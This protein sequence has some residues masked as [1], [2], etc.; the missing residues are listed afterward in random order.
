MKKGHRILVVG[1]LAAGPSAASKA[2]R[3]N[4]DAEVILIEQSPFISYRIC[5]IPYYLS[6][7]YRDTDDL[8][9]YSPERLTKDKG[10]EVWTETDAEKIEPEKRQIILR[11]TVTGKTRTERYDRLIITTGS[12]P[13]KLSFANSEH[14]NVFS[15][16]SLHAA[17][18]LR[19]YIHERKPRRAVIVGGGYIGLEMTESMK[20]LGC[21]VTLLHR[22]DY[23]FTD[24]EREAGEKIVDELE[25][26]DI[27]F[28]PQSE[29]TGFEIEGRDNV[30]AVV[31]TSQTYPADIVICAIGVS[32]N[33]ELA[34]TAGI[35][36]GLCNGILTN[37][38]QQTGVEHIYAAGDCCEIRNIISGKHVLLPLAT[39]ASKTG[40][41]AG[42]NAA[43]GEATYSGA[44]R[45]VA[46]RIFN[47]EVSRVGLTMK[48]SH[49]AEFQP[50]TKTITAFS[51]VAG[52]P[53][54]ERLTV[55]LIANKSDGR[56]LG[57][58]LIGRDGAVQRGN[59]LA[60]L[61][62]FGHSVDDLSNLDMM[63][64]PPFSTLWDPILVA[65]NQSIKK[66]ERVS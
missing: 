42:E 55:S 54:A 24:I 34:L 51:R 30:S 20:K 22:H 2:K 14:K 41:V 13:K 26:N 15:V 12:K 35:K 45:N 31:T 1:G 19:D 11:S 25:R 50:F 29:V 5:E 9:V 47:L 21:S 62:R 59:I 63:Y 58:T 38:R 64:A 28:V 65:A 40:W 16:K 18:A 7:E 52:M 39:I 56:L 60:A 46:I 33:T 53:N 6:G 4:P 27:D 66:V 8:V 17:Y 43:G 3:I 32:P 48:E 10:V 57:A 44:I 23:P 36:K 49:N 61:M 37:S